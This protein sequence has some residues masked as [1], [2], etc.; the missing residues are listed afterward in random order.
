MDFGQ[1]FSQAWKITWRYKVLWIFGL[2]SSCAASGLSGGNGTSS[3]NFPSSSSSTPGRAPSGTLPP[4]DQYQI[5]QMMERMAPYLAVFAVL[6]CVGLI[7]GIIA[8]LIGI[9]GR[10]ALVAGVDQAQQEGGTSFSKG[11]SAASAKFKPLFGMNLLLALPG[12]LMGLI[13]L[14][15]LVV[16]G[17]TMLASIAS[18]MNTSR[19]GDGA[20]IGAAILGAFACFIPLACVGFVLE[21][22]IAILRLFGERAIVLE[23]MS[24][25]D[26]LKRGWAVFRANAGN[27]ILLGI[28]LI[29]LTYVIGFVIG[30]AALPVILPIAGAMVATSA[31]TRGAAVPAAGMIALGMCGIFLLAVV[32]YVVRSALHTFSGACWNLAY[33]QF[34]KPSAIVAEPIAPTITQL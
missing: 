33:R 12:L 1:L 5:Q 28:L 11:W 21:V 27:S 31:S 24:A 30:I 17:G 9:M 25:M 29:I 16:G 7:I 10:G 23:D 4:I 20:A 13:A 14:I 34:A 3:F 19:S 2:L 8:W 26:G 15:I 22:I 6:A 32:S 18:A